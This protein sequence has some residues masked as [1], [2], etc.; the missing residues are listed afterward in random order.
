MKNENL[1]TLNYQ[2]AKIIKDFTYENIPD[3]VIKHAKLCLL[4]LLGAIFAGK[5]AKVSQL[6]QKFA[7][8]FWPGN[9]SIIGSNGSK[10]SILGASLANAFS[11]NAVD[12][13]DGYRPSKGHPG[14]LIIPAALAIAEKENKSG[15]ELLEAI[16]LGY[17]IGSRA[18][19]IWHNFY[20]IYHSSGS[21]GTITTAA[22][23]AKLMNFN[24]TQIYNSLGIA[25]WQAPMNPM[26]RCIDY[27][28]MVKDGIG[29]G[30]PTGVSSA[31]MAQLGFTGCPSLFGY[32]KYRYQI[33]S[34]GKEYKILKLYFKP[35]SCC[36][37][38]Q[39][40]IIGTLKILKE[41]SI[42]YKKIK[43]IEVFTFKES[44]RLLS[45]LPLNSEEAQ[46]NIAFPIASA[47]LFGKFN[48]NQ[49]QE[50]YYTNTGII[51]L[52]NIIEIKADERFD[53]IFPAV[54]SS[55]VVIT[56]NS[57]KIIS[58]GP[59]QAKG[60]WDCPLSDNEK[61]DKFKNLAIEKKTKS[62]INGIIET[63]FELEKISSL[64]KF[65][66]LLR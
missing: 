12:I 63:V 20:P 2:L 32:S 4:D 18:A 48:P 57:G 37:W 43:K 28:S 50:K 17:E 15:K 44:A 36:R 33:E 11:A 60:N 25:E 66:E 14:A 31:L 16:I 54:C 5:T 45:R 59:V 10:A 13:D 52:M 29:W 6:T 3:K 41:Y 38:A 46:Y 51:D 26:M 61:M 65:Y 24:E 58:S 62:E 34:I 47:A 23:T 7:E 35:F 42:D 21:W 56:L 30:C 55:E 53:K 8:Q 1:K 39:P 49:L 64:D 9:I 19:E 27:P 40:G 22:V